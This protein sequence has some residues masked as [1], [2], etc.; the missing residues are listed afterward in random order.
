MLW[1]RFY[2]RDPKGVLVDAEFTSKLTLRSLPHFPVGII[3]RFRTNTKVVYQGLML[4]AKELAEA[5]RPGKARCY[6]KLHCY[7]KRLTVVLSDVGKV[8]LIFIWQPYKLDW[9]LSILVSTIQAG[10]QELIS[11]F[12][13]RWGLEVVHR[14]LRQN[15]APHRG[16]LGFGHP[17]T[18]AGH[19]RF[20]RHR[21][22]QRLRRAHPMS[23]FAGGAN[24]HP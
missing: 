20:G 12:R 24:R 7:A 15:L 6:R 9:Q 1:V 22:L 17:G 4:Q 14:T 10:L 23:Y 11:A 3:G 13:A 2:Y 21:N 8:D 18:V 19:G 5:F 16:P